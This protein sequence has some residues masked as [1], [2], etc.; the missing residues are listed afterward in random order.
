MEGK[1]ALSKAEFELLS[2]PQR[3]LAVS[4]P[5]KMDDGT[6][7]IFL[8]YRVQANDARGP[9]KGGIRYHQSV[10]LEE[11]KTLAFLM[12]FKCAVLDLPL[13]GGK[14]G[15]I[16]DPKALS[17]AELE[18]LSRA[19][20]RSIAPVVGERIDIP[21][22]DVNTNGEVMSWMRDEYE[23]WLGKPAP[24]VITGK[25]VSNGGSL[26]REY[27]TSMGGA[28]VLREALKT[29]DMKL[30]GASVAIQ[31]FGNAG[32]HAAR[33]LHSWGAKVVAVSNSQGGLYDENGLDIPGI[34]AQYEQKRLD[35]IEGKR[36]SN[37]EL[38][39]LPVDILVPAALENQITAGNASRVK[40]KIVLELANGPVDAEGDD[41]LHAKGVFVIP[42][43]LAN[44]GGVCVS[45]FEWLQN[46]DGEY[47]TE[48]E[49]NK[50]LEETI[51]KAYTGVLDAT[52]GRKH[53][54][55]QGAYI[56]SI[57]RILEAER[58]RGRL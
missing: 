14:G 28:F 46:L 49:V 31:G 4:L 37:E 3:V 33:I 43:I 34:I 38:L 39:E 17:K 54:M 51:V 44:S 5:V 18:R 40:A 29:A 2:T 36:V 48:A 58:R 22:P 25:P 23:K 56:L 6:V 7:R 32:M 1:I 9:F 52:N 15:I 30:E 10:N 11:V 27:S 35:G 55:R 24:G 41:I 16:V 42:D 13:G 53:S 47:W 12:G 21:A 19:Y 45:Y 50:R 57:K 26:G 20:F 8:G